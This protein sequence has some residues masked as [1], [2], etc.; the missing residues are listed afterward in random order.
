LDTPV[1]AAR[2]AASAA[3]LRELLGYNFESV[4][5]YLLKEEL[6]LF[7]D[8]DSLAWAASLACA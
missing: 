6:Q 7:W 8:Y 5:A 3:G 1:Q 2:R 4:R